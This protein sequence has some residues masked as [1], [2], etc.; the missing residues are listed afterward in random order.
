MSH[1]CHPCRSAIDAATFLGTLGAQTG[2][3]MDR[4]ARELVSGLLLAAAV[5][6]AG[7]S[8]ASGL[9]GTSAAADGPGT[10]NNDNPI[11]RPIAVA[12]TSARA[13]RCGFF[14]DPAKLRA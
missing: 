11:A 12:W 1:R 4:F 10:M 2:D 9:F 3:A 14:F 8:G 13:Q 6:C 7:C 5:V